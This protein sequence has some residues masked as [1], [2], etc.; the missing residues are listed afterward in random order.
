MAPLTR[1]K[2]ENLGPV[3]HENK[4]AKILFTC[5]S[6]KISYRENFRVYGIQVSVYSYTH[7][8]N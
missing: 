7:A 3:I 6:A 8:I 2:R 4:I 5:C 1:E